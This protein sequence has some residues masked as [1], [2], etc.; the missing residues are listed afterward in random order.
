MGE[1]HGLGLLKAEQG[2]GDF[3][4]L[5]EAVMFVIEDVAALAG[6]AVALFV[7]DG[8]FADAAFD[9]IVFEHA[10]EGAVEGAGGHFDALVA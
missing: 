1:A 7:A 4:E 2:S 10:A 5:F 9:P 3:G 6:E 8:V